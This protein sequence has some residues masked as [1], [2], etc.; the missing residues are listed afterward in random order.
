MTQTYFIQASD[1]LTSMTFAPEKG[2]VGIS[3][4]MPNE[5]FSHGK[6]ELLY[7]PEGVSADNY[8]HI[9]DG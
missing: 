1:G 9:C 7:L 3:L 6:R 5:K 8:N 4:I 2:G